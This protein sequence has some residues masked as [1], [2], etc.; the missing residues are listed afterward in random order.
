MI[1]I[2]NSALVAWLTQ[3]DKSAA[4]AAKI[5][6][7]RLHTPQ[8]IDLEFLSALKGL[9][10]GK[11]LTVA[12]AEGALHKLRNPNEPITRMKHEPLVPRAWELRQNFSP[13]DA[14]YI[15][16]AEILAVPLLTADARLSRGN[17]ARCPIEVVA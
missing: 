8:L 13:Y 2:D 3:A 11:Q 14:C 16:A 6:G 15:A 10:K 12:E 9:V 5:K 1:V 17:G 4:V 7:R